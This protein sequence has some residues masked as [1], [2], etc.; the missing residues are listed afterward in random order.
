MNQWKVKTVPS[1]AKIEALSKAINVNPFMASLLIQR[2]ISTF[3]EAKAFF[4]PS[5]E[6]LHDPFLMQDMYRAVDRINEAIAKN[7]RILIFGDY[8]VDG[9]TAVSVFYGF[10]KNYYS[11]IAYYIP[12]RYKEG[13]GISYIGIDFAVDN[14]FTLIVSLDCGIKSTAHIEYAY[15]KGVDFIICDHHTPGDILPEAAAILDPKRT[16]CEY[17]Y[18][19]LSGCGV[20][21]KLLQALCIENNWEQEL[22]FEYLD[23][24]AISIAAD[25]VPITGENRIFAH[26]GMERINANPRPGLQAIIELAALKLPIDISKV[27]FTFAPRINAAGRLA[28]A[29][30]AVRLMLSEDKETALNQAKLVNEHNTNRRELDADITQEAL[31]MF[32]EDDFLKNASSSV[33]YSPSW[34][35]G[36]VG[37]VASRVIETYYRPTIVLTESE[38]K[39]VGSARSVHDFNLY[40]AIDACSDLL[41]QF[42]GHTAAAGLTLKPENLP[43]FKLAFEEAVKLRITPEQKQPIIYIDVEILLDAITPQFYNIIKQLAPFGP[44]NMA[45]V[46]VANNLKAS[47]VKILKEEHLKFDVKQEGCNSQFSAI[48][49]RMAH[50]NDLVADNKIFSL[51]FTIEENTFRDKTTLQF[52]VRD[53]KP[54]GYNPVS[55]GESTESKACEYLQEKGYVIKERNYRSGKNE[56][57]II[58]LKNN[59]L[60][61]VEVKY[62]KND[63]FGFPESMVDKS[64]QDRIKACA[65]D[66]IFATNWNG[67]IR[68][69]IISIIGTKPDIMHFEDAFY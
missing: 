52:M 17:P 64:K 19:E 21:F 13:Y 8:D 42:G 56:I 3:D 47:N 63:D 60:I 40:E 46:F 34:H 18:K 61:F 51:C 41:E 14:D 24:L 31:T 9:T 4:R 15:Q 58:A 29:C 45:P 25:I 27:V 67:G 65:N 33:L 30:D 11:N 39:I 12:D 26:F 69:E 43:A 10:L 37:I 54:W 68:F 66:Y 2:G 38:G 32:K 1:K 59:E 50:L 20:G 36:V 48:G 35:K 62:R 6:A 44:Q 22:L 5:L 16:D 55:K 53:I 57:D 7:E 49:F 28:D 23:L